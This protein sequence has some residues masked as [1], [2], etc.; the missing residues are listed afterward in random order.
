[1]NKV[2]RNGEKS[3]ANM[4]PTEFS[5]TLCWA[6]SSHLVHLFVPVPV[7]IQARFLEDDL[8]VLEADGRRSIP[9]CHAAD[10]LTDERIELLAAR[11]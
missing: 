9:S 10:F 8:E 5:P 7:A 1:M 11:K 4:I 6:W 3:T 2:D